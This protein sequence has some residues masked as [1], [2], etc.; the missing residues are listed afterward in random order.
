MCNNYDHLVWLKYSNITFPG[1]A[2]GMMF[3]IKI[4]INLKHVSYIKSE[5]TPTKVRIINNPEVW[6]PV[7]ANGNWN[8]FEMVLQTDFTNNS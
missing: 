4:Q 8:I 6:T 1:I 5:S 2:K 7:P 3:R